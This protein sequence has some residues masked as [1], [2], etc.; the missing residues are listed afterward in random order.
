MENIVVII[1]GFI[2]F[3]SIGLAALNLKDP[4]DKE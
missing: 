3:A 2:F 4:D 1:I